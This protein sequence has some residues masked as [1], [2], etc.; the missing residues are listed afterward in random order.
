MKSIVTISVEGPQETI[1][2]TANKTLSDRSINEGFS[3]MI[4]TSI[5]PVP[6]GGRYLAGIRDLRFPGGPMG[7]YSSASFAEL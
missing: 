1:S 2:T 6:P 7:G 3:L 5:V 4:E